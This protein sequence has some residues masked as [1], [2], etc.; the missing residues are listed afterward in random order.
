[1]KLLLDEQID[2]RVAVQIRQRGNDALGIQENWG[3]RTLSDD[4]VLTLA[5]EE[6][7]TLVTRNIAD[8]VRLHT[9]RMARGEH[10]CGILL[11][12]GRRFPNGPG[13]IGPMVQA[14]EMR[15]AADC[16]LADTYEFL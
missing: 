13:A 14:L 9:Q 10:H 1:M 15:L 6:G 8:F 3:L 5:A 12:H 2:P 7:R 16:D 11:V 4:L